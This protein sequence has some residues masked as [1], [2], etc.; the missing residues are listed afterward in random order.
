MN[1]KRR[2]SG[3]KPATPGSRRKHLEDKQHKLHAQIGKLEEFIAGSPFQERRRKIATRDI[4]APPE[5]SRQ[6]A[7]KRKKRLSRKHKLAARQER[8][9]HLFNFFC[10]FLLLCAILYW[11]F[12]P[13]FSM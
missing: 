4:I 9:R 10:L 6:A 8:H 2:S 7:P 5:H 3:K 11:L 13:V 1:K 12:H